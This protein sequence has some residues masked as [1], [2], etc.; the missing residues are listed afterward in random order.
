MGR[1][2][3]ACRSCERS[4][5]PTLFAG[6]HYISTNDELG[7]VAHDAWTIITGLAARTSVLRLGTM[8][9]SVTFRPPAVLANAV[10]TADH[11]S[12]A[13]SSSGSGQGGWSESTRRSASRSRARGCA[14][15]CSPSSSRSCTACGPRN[16][17]RSTAATTRSKRARQ[18]EAAAISPSPDH[19][20]W[21][22]HAGHDAAGRALRRRVQR[23]M[24]L[25]SP[26]FPD[27]RQRVIEACGDVGRD[28]ATMRFSIA[29]HCIVG[30]T[31][32]EAMDRARAIYDLGP[33]DQ[34]FDNWFVGAGEQRLFARSTRSQPH[35]FRMPR[36]APIG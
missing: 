25:A 17:S 23:L 27:V 22:R 5:V 9:R 32:D 21:Q 10:A 33:R 14:S 2:V 24:G 36:L 7:K 19:R 30:E 1:L 12:A 20:R 11:I 3:R 13:G 15:R 16:G 8:V 18:A 29:I 26:E 35:Y 28:P 34:S 4:A 31:R 6:D